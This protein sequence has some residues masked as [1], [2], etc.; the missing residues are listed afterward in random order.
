MSVCSP[1]EY[2][3][4]M[5]ETAQKLDVPFVDVGSIFREKIDAVKA[6]QLYPAEA[7]YYQ[8]LYGPAAMEN[9]WRY[10]VTT[11]G[12]HPNRVGQNLVADALADAVRSTF[13]R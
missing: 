11:D 7:R 10:W 6:G 3:A 8:D 12:C 4:A 13:G 9:F 1:D 2:V 5:R